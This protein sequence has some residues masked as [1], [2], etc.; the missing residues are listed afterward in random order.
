MLFA[1]PPLATSLALSIC[2]GSDRVMLLA[3]SLALSI[4]DGSDAG[5]WLCRAVGL[6]ACPDADKISCWHLRFDCLSTFSD[7]FPTLPASL[8]GQRVMDQCRCA[9]P[10]IPPPPPPAAANA[11]NQS[12]PL[13][14]SG[15]AVTSAKYAQAHMRHGDATVNPATRLHGFQSMEVSRD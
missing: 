3:T 10:P 9:C 8:E 11:A 5:P 1:L 15:R 13:R 6:G 14:Q 7:L 12:A 2:D 4:C